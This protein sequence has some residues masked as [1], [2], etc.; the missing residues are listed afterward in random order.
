M[1]FQHL[2]SFMAK[3]LNSCL[4]WFAILRYHSIIL[5][6]LTVHTMYGA[7]FKLENIHMSYP[8]I[9]RPSFIRLQKYHIV[10]HNGALIQCNQL[11]L[12]TLIYIK[13]DRAIILPNPQ[14]PPADA[15]WHLFSSSCKMGCI[16]NVQLEVL[17]QLIYLYDFFKITW[18][19][20]QWAVYQRQLFSL[21]IGSAISIHLV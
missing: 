8:V 11:Q 7:D 21:S 1:Y 19:R 17:V 5:P 6:S 3:T 18:H 10:Q 2:V 9:H 20:S 13:A 4:L 14:H 15:S 12:I 16:Q